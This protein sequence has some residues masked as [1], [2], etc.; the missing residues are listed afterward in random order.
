M[1]E[2]P[3]SPLHC[4][5]EAV[6]T[7]PRNGYV[8][9]MTVTVALDLPP[10]ATAETPDELVQRLRLLWALDEIRQG[11]MT[12]VRAAHLLGLGLDDFLQVA[13]EHGLHAIDYD[14]DDFQQELASGT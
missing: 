6:A 14:L 12:R 7:G 4:L 1:G 9:W 5:T 10:D 3:P 2:M 13:S 8:V 11:R